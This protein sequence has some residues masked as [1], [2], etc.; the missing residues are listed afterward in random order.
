MIA[1]SD[2]EQTLR[3]KHQDVSLRVMKVL[4]EDLIGSE[5]LLKYLPIIIKSSHDLADLK[6]CVLD[7]EDGGSLF[8]LQ[9]VRKTV[10]ELTVGCVAL[11]HQ[12]SW[13][14]DAQESQA[15]AAAAAA[16]ARPNWNLF[17]EALAVEESAKDLL[18]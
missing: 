8:A 14:E 7:H 1:A 13:R 4:R 2:I 17:T 11:I 18:Q 15:Q 6:H 16:T 9:C 5:A 12:G 10:W 3:R